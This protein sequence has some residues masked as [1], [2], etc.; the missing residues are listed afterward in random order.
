[1]LTLRNARTYVLMTVATL[2]LTACQSG[3]TSNPVNNPHEAATTPEQHAFA[4]YG[5]WVI[6]KEAAADIVELPDTPQSVR[7]E[8]AKVDAAA[9]PIAEQMYD[10]AQ[11]AFKI[12]AQ[13][14][15]G[16]SNE[17]KLQV[18][19]VNL[20]KWVEQLEPKIRE[21]SKAIGKVGG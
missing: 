12:R 7:E 1:M 6:A 3:C 13:I 19:L 2:F 5:E 8:V 15:A 9:S 17:E 20:N 16:T 11:D 10:A 21:L 14:Q 4:V 18:V